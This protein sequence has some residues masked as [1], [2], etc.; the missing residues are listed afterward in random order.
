MPTNTA[1]DVSAW[2]DA[3]H[4]TEQRLG[5][6][7]PDVGSVLAS[8]VNRFF[9]DGDVHRKKPSYRARLEPSILEFIKVL[10]DEIPET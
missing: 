4:E 5:A 3:V 10:R 1:G 2:Y 6:R 7:F 9:A 8:P